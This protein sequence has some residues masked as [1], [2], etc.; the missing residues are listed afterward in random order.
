MAILTQNKDFPLFYTGWYGN[1][2]DCE[3]LEL[4]SG[5]NATN[6]ARIYDEIQAI[7]IVSENKEGTLPYSGF[8]NIPAFI[9]VMPLK[10]LECGRYYKIILKPG[11]GSLEIPNFVYSTNASDDINRLTTG[12]I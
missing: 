6:Y 1:C 2:D 11:E 10:R 8:Q 5:T 9:G 4:I 3:P 12:C 7:F